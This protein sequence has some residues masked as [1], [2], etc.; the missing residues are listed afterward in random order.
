MAVAV[1]IGKLKKDNQV[2]VYQTGRWNEILQ[3]S[4]AQGAQLGL[5]EEFV[6]GMME[7]IHL[8]S[9]RKQ[10]EVIEKVQ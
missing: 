10:E 7:L 9:I 6:R 2:T 4:I 3:K 8:E 5:G 1:K